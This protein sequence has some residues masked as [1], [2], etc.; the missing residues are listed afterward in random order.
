MSIATDMER[1]ARAKV[2]LK[3]AIIAQGVSVPDSTKIDGYAYLVSQISGGGSGLPAGY[4]KLTYIESSGTQYI[5]T[6]IIPTNDLEVKMKFR[7]AE[8]N[9]GSGQYNAIFGMRAGASPGNDIFWCGYYPAQ[10]KVMIQLGGTAVNYAVDKKSGIEFDF[11]PPSTVKVNGVT[12]GAEYAS[13]SESA[14]P[15]YIFALNN[16]SSSNIAYYSSALLFSVTF[17]RN[18]VP[19]FNGIPCKRDQD[20]AIGL[21]DTVSETFKGNSGT[22]SFTGL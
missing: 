1:L 2:D 22:G 15:I 20:G 9:S 6:G 21:Y 4:T 8:I 3:A 16:I 5:N 17:L 18:G 13:G 12:T 11:T 14:N 19:V 7:Y 10:S